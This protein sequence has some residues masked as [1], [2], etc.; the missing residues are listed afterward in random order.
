MGLIYIWTIIW[1]CD[2]KMRTLKLLNNMNENNHAINI[3][4]NLFKGKT[5]D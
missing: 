1:L 5:G 3:I 4:E 2:G